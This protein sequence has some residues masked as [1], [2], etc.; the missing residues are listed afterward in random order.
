MHN[1][2]EVMSGF[3]ATRLSVAKLNQ[4]VVEQL[5]RC[6][7]RAVGACARERAIPARSAKPYT[8]KTV[9][10]DRTTQD[11]SCTEATRPAVRAR[12]RF[13]PAQT[14]ASLN[15]DSAARLGGSVNED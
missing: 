7:V 6:G 8:F 12:A 5:A 11:R 4:V 15:V 10:A 13:H 3:V 2:E 14:R 1:A 9:M